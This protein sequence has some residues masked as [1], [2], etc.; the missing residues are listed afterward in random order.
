MGVSARKKNK[1]GMPGKDR[2]SKGSI[3]DKRRAS[4]ALKRVT[5]CIM[6]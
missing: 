5:R 6:M 2:E 3:T 4:R 1:R